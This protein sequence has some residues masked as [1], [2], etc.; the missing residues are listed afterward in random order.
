MEALGVFLFD[1]IMFT[2]DAEDHVAWLLQHGW[3]EKALEAV[4][5]GNGRKELFDEVLLVPLT[6]WVGSHVGRVASTTPNTRNNA[7]T[8]VLLVHPFLVDRSVPDTSITWYWRGNMTRLQ[9]FAQ[10]YCVAL[11]QP[12]KGGI[13]YR[14]YQSCCHL[15][16]RRS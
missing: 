13:L 3:Y 11:P 6:V 4:E 12:G 7:L 8:R 1:L 9:H 16:L 14:N 10:S 15:A 5:A 2:R